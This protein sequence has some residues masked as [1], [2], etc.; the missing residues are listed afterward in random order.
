MEDSCFVVPMCCYASFIAATVRQRGLFGLDG[1]NL[2]RME[3][4]EMASE[5]GGH[6]PGVDARLSSRPPWRATVRC[7]GAL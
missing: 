4:G 5:G 2:Q 7:P 6:G 1:P 3:R